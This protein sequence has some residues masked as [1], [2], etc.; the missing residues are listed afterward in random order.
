MLD[1]IASLYLGPS[2]GPCSR[3]RRGTCWLLDHLAAVDAEA[4]Q[5]SGCAKA[6]AMHSVQGSLAALGW[7]G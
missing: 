7:H 6:A 5:A 2:R 3:S 1:G 4:Q